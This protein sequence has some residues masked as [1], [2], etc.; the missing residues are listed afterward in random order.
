MKI[1][2][3]RGN[4]NGSNEELENTIDYLEKTLKLGYDV[5]IDIWYHN[6]NLY[7]G[8]D[9]PLYKITID[10]LINNQDKLWLHCK[11]EN[12]LFHLKKYQNLNIFY[13]KSDEFTITS[14]NIILINPFFN[15][16]YNRGILMMPELS[17][18]YDVDIIKFDG[19]ITD[20]IK[21]Y[22]NYYNNVR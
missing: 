18:F 15:T 2:S 17:M 5:E 22:E 10:W 11:D 14:K 16:K 19:I 7:L 20:D 12:S 9:K 13:H 1:I 6:E 8:H 21:R 3:H 4:I